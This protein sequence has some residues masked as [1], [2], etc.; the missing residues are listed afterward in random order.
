MTPTE[1][2][3]RLR[4]GQLRRVRKEQLLKENKLKLVEYYEKLIE[5]ST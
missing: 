1:F 3:I 2:G 5:W 4:G